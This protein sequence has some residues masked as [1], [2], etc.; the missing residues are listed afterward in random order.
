MSYAAWGDMPAEKNVSISPSP[1][2]HA[3]V[4]RMLASRRFDNLRTLM[5]VGLRLLDE[6]ET[7]LRR[8]VAAEG[9]AEKTLEGFSA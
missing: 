6:R 1:E 9:T 7:D 4:E 8:P 5:R 3:V 2:F